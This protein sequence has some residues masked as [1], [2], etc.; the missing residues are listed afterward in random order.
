MRASVET[1]TTPKNAQLPIIATMR[2]GAKMMEDVYP[3]APPV[4]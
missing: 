1:H 3:R 4:A 2:T